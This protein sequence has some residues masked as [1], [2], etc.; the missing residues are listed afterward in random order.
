MSA[1][2]MARPDTP[3][4][5]VA[6]LDSFDSAVLQHLMDAVDLRGA[7]VDQRFAIAGQVRSSRTGCGGTKLAVNK[8]CARKRATHTASIV[9]SP[10]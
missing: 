10:N 9:S 6:K 3:I 5:S 4:T 7:L 8:P 1:R 2:I